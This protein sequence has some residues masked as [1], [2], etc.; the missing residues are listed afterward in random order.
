MRRLLPIPIFLFLATLLH[1]QTLT[2]TVRGTIIDK[3][4]H[5]PLVGAVVAIIGTNPFKGATTD[6]KGNFRIEG[7][8]IGRHT[9]R[10]S[11]LGYQ[12]AV[13]SNLEITSGKEVVLNIEL[14]EK[15]PESKEVVITA[16]RPKDKPLNEMAVVSAQTVTMEETQRFAGALGDPARMAADYAGV[17]IGSDARN[18]III[19]GNSPTGLLWRLEGVDIPN[20]NHF[21]AQGTTGGPVSI[22]NSNLLANSDF[23][24][25]AFPAE[26]GNA[27]SGVFDLRMRTGNNEKHEFTGQVGFNG[28]EA[29]AE[30]PIKKEG[31][32][33]LISYR[34]S[35]LS[36][37][38]AVGINL[39]PAGIPKYQDLS[40]KINLPTKKAGIFQIF[41]V[42]GMSTITIIDKDRKSDN[43][44]YGYLNRNIYFSSNMGAIGVV[45][46]YLLPKHGYFRTTIAL[47]E[48]GHHNTLDSLHNGD[49]INVYNEKTR[50]L[51]LNMHSLLNYKFNASNTLKSGIIVNTF[52]FNFDQQYLSKFFGKWVSLGT[53]TGSTWMAE[54]YSEWKHN[55]SNRFDLLAG[56]HFQYLFLNNTYAIEPRAG[57][58]YKLTDSKT[59]SFGYGLHSQMQPFVEYIFHFNTPSG[60]RLQLNHD[61]GF[62]KSEHFVLGYNQM[63]SKNLH[64]KAEAYYQYLFDVPVQNPAIYPG[65]TSFSM[66]NTGADFTIAYTPYLVNQGVGRNYGLELTLERFFSKGYY[67]LFTTSLFD[68]K[69]KGSDNIWRNTAFNSHEVVNGLFG[70]EFAIGGNK[71]LTLSLKGTYAGGRYH[72]PINPV[73][74]AFVGQAVYD[75]S[76][77]FSLEFPDYF[78]I[79]FRGGLKINSK[80]ISQEIALDV[81][82]V[83]NQKNVLTEIYDP[84][85]NEVRQEYQL[86]I[87]PV[88]LYRIQF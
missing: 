33:Y 63:L 80:K 69:Y 52:F 12:E 49:P 74:S 17:A 16:N 73:L 10:A 87:F 26:Y 55:F 82:N 76:K 48:E 50:M 61:M 57:L 54:A 84:Q 70:K 44:T 47:T 28:A 64:F 5:Q 81:A 86:G 66:L 27:T 18:D 46:S 72:T 59:L 60:Q 32:S 39:G 2:Q 13:L 30:G 75:Q 25:S 43:F 79:D 3:E 65:G 14:T 31:A 8:P 68:S 6:E 23:L 67:F 24:T 53:D 38:Q 71:F 85:K 4:S 42:G 15:I 9:L 58:S 88:I 1:A 83:T 29:M 11:L 19:R 41:G 20:P 7:V 36:F 56:V 62:T 37:F 40:F 21:A 51:Q 78:K 77:A 35:V 22:L 34:Y 45:H